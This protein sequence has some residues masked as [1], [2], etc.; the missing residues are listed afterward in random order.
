M[1]I[2]K[3]FTELPEAATAGMSDIICA[4]QG[5]ISPSVLGISVQE[6]LQQVY[7][8]FQANVILFYSGNPNGFVAGTTFQ[9]CWDTVNE[10]M[11]VCTTSGTSSTAVWTPIAPSASTVIT[12]QFGG[13]GISEN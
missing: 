1:A 3:K 4:V 9:L 8:L 5:Y 10:I 6:T 11:Y 13:T 12:P 2:E 7:D